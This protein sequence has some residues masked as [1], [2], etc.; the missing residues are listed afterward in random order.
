M[1]A[2]ERNISLN[3]T[4]MLCVATSW[5]SPSPVDLAGGLPGLRMKGD[6]WVPYDEVDSSFERGDVL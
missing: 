3:G 6:G 4:F 2:A 1:V 5:G